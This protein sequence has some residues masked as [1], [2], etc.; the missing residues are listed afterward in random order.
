MN[1]LPNHFNKPTEDWNKYCF[2]FINKKTDELLLIDSKDEDKPIG[3][4]INTVEFFDMDLGIVP[5]S[6]IPPPPSVS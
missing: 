6:Q 3:N 4:L 1:R 2:G 5:L